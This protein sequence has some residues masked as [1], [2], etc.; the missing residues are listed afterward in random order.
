LNILDKF[1]PSKYESKQMVDISPKLR[2]SHWR[3][4]PRREIAHDC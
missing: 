1:L 4:E 3:F 2:F